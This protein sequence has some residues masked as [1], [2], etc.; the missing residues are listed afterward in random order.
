MATYVNNLRL[1]EIATGD[2]S[3]TWGSSTNT[4]LELIGEALG[5][6]TEAITTNAD[7]HTTTIADGSSDAGRAMYLKYTGTLDSACTITIAPNT[8]KRM[9][10]IENGTSGSQNIIISQGSGANITIPPGDTKAVYLDGAGSGAA[11][12][13]A[14]ASLNT[15]DLKVEDDLTVTDDATIGGTLGV[16]GVL[17]ANAG[18]VVDNIT[19]DGT[20]IDL[21]SGDLTLDVAG[22]IVLDAD[23]EQVKFSDG[24]TEIGQIDM[25]SNNFTLRSKVSDADFEIHGTDGSSNIVALAFDMSEAGAATFNGK[26]TADAG[27]DIDNFNIDGTT[28]ALSSGD[29]T[30]D[31][32]GRIDLSAD[33]NGEVR[34]F[35]GSLHYGQF[36]EDSN[37]FI[38]QSVISDADIFIQGNDN[39]SVINAVQFDMSDAGRAIF[40]T[41]MVIHDSTALANTTFDAR[42]V[43][44]VTSLN[45]QN[46]SATIQR[47]QS[48]TA[49]PT[50]V[51]NK[52]RGSLGS[53][54]DV[55][56]GDFTGSV[57][58]R[59]YH[60]SGFHQTAS[61]ESKVSGTP[62]DSSDMPGTLIFSTSPDGSATPTSKLEIDDDGKTSLKG[63]TTSG[64][65]VLEFTNGSVT[66]A[67]E[68]SIAII[69]P[70]VGM[71]LQVQ[72]V[73]GVGGNSFPAGLFFTTQD[74]TV[75]VV[76]DPESQFSNAANTDNKINIYTEA[77]AVR[78]QNKIGA[79]SPFAIACFD[80][81]GV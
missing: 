28:I 50:L 54:A 62:G 39:S 55:N 19:I 1:K 42:D 21:S 45:V 71:M 23:G 10:F 35:D 80:F 58:F 57:L 29:I 4:N 69:S 56:N 53:E 61:I 26:I 68:A 33:D 32:A 60:G 8:M 72:A 78:L 73:K 36:K 59:G 76:A 70:N 38:I 63:G 27:I 20:E 17:T 43:D 52:A 41:G 16:T 48:A 37:S 30:M 51:F 75:T 46:N 65:Q 5:F 77:G 7:T 40:P 24:G 66:V 67:D 13:D 79:G 12:V 34:L 22:D 74:S 14:F 64:I 44:N 15:V 81:K 49:A 9:Q 25:G 3:G 47:S 18:V 6:G 2:E 11:V 31:A